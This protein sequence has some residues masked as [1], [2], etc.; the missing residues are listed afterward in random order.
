MRGEDFMISRSIHLPQHAAAAVA[1]L[2]PAVPVLLQSRD[3]DYLLCQECH[4]DQLV[5][6]LDLLV[7]IG[8]PLNDSPPLLRHHRNLILPILLLFS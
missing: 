7:V 5:R 2:V 6:C 4:W 8:P 1:R 3:H